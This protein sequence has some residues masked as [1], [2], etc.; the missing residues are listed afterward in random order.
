M[1]ELIVKLPIEIQRFILSYTY[2]P[3]KKETLCDIKSYVETKLLMKNKHKI[4]S[5]LTPS[6]DVNVLFVNL[7]FSYLTD[8]TII[9]LNKS[10]QTPIN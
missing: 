8:K 7:L 9:Q 10:F 1:R 5:M 2:S 3:Q 4:L 6:I